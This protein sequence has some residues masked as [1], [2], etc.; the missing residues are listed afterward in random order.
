MSLLLHDKNL[1]ELMEDFYVLTGIKIVLF[2]KDF[3]EV[4]SYPQNKESFCSIMRKNKHF[5][6]KCRECDKIS[7]SK[8][9]KDNPLN[10]YKCHAGLIE[11]TALVTEN[12]RIIGYLMFG[13]ITDNKNRAEFASN[14][15]K[16]C[17]DY[18]ITENLDYQIKKIK[19]RNSRQ[20]LA[21]SKIM[22]A[23]TGYIQLKE[24]LRSSEKNQVK[25]IEKYIDSHLSED[26]SIKR[27]CDEFHISRTQLY[28]LM[29]EHGYGK[30]ANFI[31]SK[32]LE[33]AKHLL[34]TTDMSIAEISVAVGFSD[35]NYFLKS[36]KK[37]YG[38]SPKQFLKNYQMRLLSTDE[39]LV[40]KITF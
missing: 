14:I 10:I 37:E 6:E 12:G 35:Y 4:A 21:A 9:T 28:N 8:C 1:M 18:E 30:I 23:C 27:L 20:I 34:K 5:D 3:N 7:L 22:D 11:A 16:L 31:R 15:E 17:K 29:S 32:R 24:M 26:I 13:Q 19:Y 33:R 25:Y 38:I 39:T 2:D 36:F 40:Q